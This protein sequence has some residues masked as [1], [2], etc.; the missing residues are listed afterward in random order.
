MIEVLAVRGRTTVQDLGRPGLAHLG[1]PPSGAADAPALMLANRLVGNPPGAGA[2]ELTLAG[3]RLRFTRPAT[4]AYVEPAGAAA[5]RRVAAGSELDLGRV[6]GGARAY[7]AVRGG[8]AV[9]P[10][11]GSR[12]TDGLSGLGPAPLAVGD[13]L[14]VGEP[15]GPMPGVDVAPRGPRSLELRLLPGPR[16]DRVTPLPAG[17]AFAVLPAGDRTGIRLRG[18]RLAH[19]DDAE[20]PSEGVVT[21]S[22]QVPPSGDPILLLADHPVTGG[23]PVVGVLMEE[24]VPHAAQLVPGDRVTIRPVTHPP[25]W[26]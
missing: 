4:V 11:L 13:V 26:E 16:A 22:L 8:I 1:V 7:L 10:V 19:L 12:A 15:D 23:Y 2:L 25:G 20:L 3:P 18:P 9:P 21:G 6:Q 24:D 14:P 17:A 5:P